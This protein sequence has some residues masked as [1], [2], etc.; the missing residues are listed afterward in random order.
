MKKLRDFECKCGKIT[1]HFVNDDV[2]IVQCECGK[3]ARC[4]LSAPKF[5][6]NSC[7]NNA[8]FSKNKG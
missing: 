8:S 6:G 3:G 4:T 1:E 5:T 2:K 7:G